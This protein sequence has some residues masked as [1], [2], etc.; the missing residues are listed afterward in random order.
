M[1]RSRRWSRPY[2]TESHLLYTHIPSEW[3]DPRP[4]LHPYSETPLFVSARKEVKQR[5][6]ERK[7]AKEAKKD[8]VR[9]GQ[10]GVVAWGTMP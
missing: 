6:K 2:P 8:K 7:K 5:E 3:I 10:E 1:S 9:K 4:H